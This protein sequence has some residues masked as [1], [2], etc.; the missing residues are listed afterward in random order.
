MDNFNARLENIKWQSG[1]PIRMQTSKLILIAVV[2]RW[3]KDLV[4][5]TALCHKCVSA[6]GRIDLGFFC[7]IKRVKI[8]VEHMVHRLLLGEPYGLVYLTEK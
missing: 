7:L 1:E 4:T 5:H 3:S 6:L 2:V 8:S